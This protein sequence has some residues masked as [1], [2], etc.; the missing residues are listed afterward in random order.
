M[1]KKRIRENYEN[2]DYLDE[3]GKVRTKVIYR[4]AY[5]APADPAAIK[6]F[7]AVF[8]AAAFLLA[9]FYVV[10]LLFDSPSLRAVYF[11]LP[12]VGQ[13]FPV[14]FLCL[15]AFGAAFRK[16]PYREETKRGITDTPRKWCFAGNVL[17]LVSMGGYVAA[18]IINGFDYASLLSFVCA[19]ACFSLYI[20]IRKTAGSLKLVKTE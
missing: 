5:Y 8:A 7:R 14:F 1:D 11:V 15:S 12:Y 17:S 18:Q 20:I 6:P 10:P 4:G 19:A 16:P 2:V 13:V 9:V 3:N